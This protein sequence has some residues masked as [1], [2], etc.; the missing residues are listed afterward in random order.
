MS[1]KNSTAER[2]TITRDVVDIEEKTGN[3]YESI[4]MLGKR[5]NQIN[6]EL[7]EELTRKLQE[8]AS[9][10]DN[11]EEIFENRE[12]IEIS[13]FYEK[14]PKPVAMAIQEL[15]EDKIYQRKLEE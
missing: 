10:T 11:L 5:A 12:Q 9:S 4:A 15:L 2:T 1:F 8:F 7:K 13:R 14:L 6:V 3:V